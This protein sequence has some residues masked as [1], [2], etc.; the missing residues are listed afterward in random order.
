MEHTL[1]SSS[2]RTY[3]AVIA[4]MTASAHVYIGSKAAALWLQERHVHPVLRP[5]FES[6]LG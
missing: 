4:R 1:H 2:G 3:S 6:R 5:F